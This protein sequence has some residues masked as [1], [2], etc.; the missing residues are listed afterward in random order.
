[1]NAQLTEILRLLT[2]LIRIGTISDVD[3][4]NGLCRVKTGELETTWLNWLT[5]RAGN[6]RTWWAPSVGEQVIILS[7]AGELTTAFVLPAVFS[8]ANPAPSGSDSD[9]VVTFQ[10]G[11]RF[12]YSPENGELAIDGIKTA[13]FKASTGITLDTPK[14]TCTKLLETAELSVKDGGEMRGDIRHSGGEFSSNGVVVDTH[15]HSGVETGS[16]NSGGPVK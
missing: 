14:V 6:A 8:D 15:Q 3:T 11:A 1:M 12:S 4:E 5:M 7:M 13:V 9:L 2:N 10:D 16:G